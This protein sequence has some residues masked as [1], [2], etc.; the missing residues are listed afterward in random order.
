M[1]GTQEEGETRRAQAEVDRR[2]RLDRMQKDTA[3]T[4]KQ[5]QEDFDKVSICNLS[6]SSV[7]VLCVH[8]QRV[9]TV[10]VCA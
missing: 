1:Q 4:V 10:F 7:P 3:A 9:Y 5:L 6:A 2:A 8:I